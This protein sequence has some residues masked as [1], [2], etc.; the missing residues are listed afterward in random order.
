PWGNS[1]ARVRQW[2]AERNLSNVELMVG[3]AAHMAVHYREAHVTL[4]PFTDLQRAK[5]A[6]NSLIESLACGRPVVI[7]EA[8]GL[9]PLVREA[10]AGGRSFWEIYSRVARHSVVIA[11]G[12][13]PRQGEFDGSHDLRVTRLRLAMPAWGVCSMAG[14]GGYWQAVSQLRRIVRSKRV[15][16]VHCS[17]CLPE[18]VMALALKYAEG[19]PYL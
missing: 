4:A 12:E 9:A 6:P 5:P 8:V 18:G 19:L 17:R 7:S 10:G 11:A 14:L 2:I 16:A 15:T 1:A 13:D 3:Y